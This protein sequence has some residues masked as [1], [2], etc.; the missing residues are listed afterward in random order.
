MINQFKNKL[1]G[2]KKNIAKISS[3][4]LLGQVISVITLPIIT[5]IYGAEVIGIWTLLNSIFMLQ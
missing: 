4:T 2:N 1:S 3:G 5:R